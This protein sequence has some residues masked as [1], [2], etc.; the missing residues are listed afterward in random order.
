MIHKRLTFWAVYCDIQNDS[1]L[2]LVSI[3]ATAANRT[4]DLYT[5]KNVFT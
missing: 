3:M 4:S 1:Q 5:V 2:P